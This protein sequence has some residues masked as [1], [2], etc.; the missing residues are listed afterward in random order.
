MTQRSIQVVSKKIHGTGEFSFNPSRAVRLPLHADAQME[1][2]ATK[3][4]S[5]SVPL[6]DFDRPV[7]GPNPHQTQLWT[8]SAV[9]EAREWSSAAF[10]RFEVSTTYLRDEDETLFRIAILVPRDTAVDVALDAEDRLRSHLFGQFRSEPLS[11]V[12]S[13]SL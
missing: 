1:W 3:G 4:V 8:E 13:R 5:S 12:V 9:N 6:I 10:Q 7:P 2:W 11:V